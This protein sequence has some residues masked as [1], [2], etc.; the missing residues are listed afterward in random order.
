MN[1]TEC[2]LGP[3]AVS[4]FSDIDHWGGK[5]VKIEFQN[6]KK[7]GNNVFYKVFLLFLKKV[8]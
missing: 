5:S 1:Y 4:H 6:K 2:F 3:K 7:V 8:K